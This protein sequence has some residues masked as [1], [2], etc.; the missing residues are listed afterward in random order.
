MK[1]ILSLGSLLLA[2]GSCQSDNAPTQTEASTDQTNVSARLVA[3]KALPLAQSFRARM[4]VGDSVGEWSDAP[5]DKGAQLTLGKVKRGTLVVL[6]VRGYSVVGNDTLWKWFAH[7]SDSAKGAVLSIETAVEAIEPPVI[8]KGQILKLP[9]GSWYTTSATSW[10]NPGVVDSTGTIPALSTSAVVRVRVRVAVP[11]TKDTLFGDTLRLNA[12]RKPTIQP[13]NRTLSKTDSVRISGAS[14]DSLVYCE[15]TNCSDWKPYAK[16][17]PAK[18][19]VLRARAWRDGL[20]SPIDT[21][22]FALEGDPVV[23]EDTVV[24]KPS[25]SP[26]AGTVASTD[27]ITLTPANSGDSIRY[28]TDGSEWKGYT[29]PFPVGDFTV[30]AVALRGKYVSAIAEAKYTVSTTKPSSPSIASSCK[31]LD[32]CD[33][34]TTFEVTSKDSGVTLLYALS[35][36]SSKWERYTSKVP[37]TQS[38]TVFARAVRKEDSSAVQ[39]LAFVIIPPDTVKFTQ[40]RRN[41]DTV[42][43][44]LSTTSGTIW[45]ARGASGA[46]VQYSDSIAVRVRDS[47]R[48][49]SRRGTDSSAPKVFRAVGEKPNPPKFIRLDTLISAKDSIELEAYAPGDVVQYK[50]AEGK[51]VAYTGK[52]APPADGRIEITARSLRNG[53]HSDSVSKAFRV[54]ATLPASPKIDRDT[55]IPGDKFKISVVE[56]NATLEV[57]PDT[58]G[59]SWQSKGTSLEFAASK[60]TM[61]LARSRRGDKVSG[62][63][64]FTIGIRQPDTVRFEASPYDIDTVLVVLR[65]KAGTIW[66]S[67]GATNDSTTYDDSVPVRVN[68]SLWAWTILGTGRSAVKAFFA[69]PT[70]PQSPKITQPT[71]S[72]I[73]PTD[74]IVLVPSARGDAVQYNLGAKWESYTGKIKPGS[75]GPFQ[76]SIRSLRNGLYSDSISKSFYVDTA[77]LA[78]PTISPSIAGVKLNPGTRFTI[79][80]ETG[81][82]LQ[83]STDLKSWRDTTASLEFAAQSDVTIHARAKTAK[84]TSSERTFDIKIQ[85]PDTVKFSAVAHGP[86]S[87]QLTITPVAGDTVVYKRAKNANPA[88]ETKASEAV[89]QIILVPVNDSVTAWTKRGTAYGDKRGY[90][91]APTAPNVPKVSPKG[92][93]VRDTSGIRLSAATPG[94]SVYYRIGSGGEWTPYVNA[95]MLPQGDV[96]LDVR[97]SRNG[98]ST[99]T[100]IGFSVHARPS[101]PLVEGCRSACDPGTTLTFKA[102]VGHD[103][104]AR[105]DAGTPSKRTNPYSAT[106]TTTNTKV[107]AYAD[108]LGYS[109]PDTCVTVTIK[110]PVAPTIAGVRVVHGEM[111]D[112]AYV[113]VKAT[114]VDDQLMATFGGTNRNPVKVATTTFTTIYGIERTSTDSAF[115]VWTKRGTA[116]STQAKYTLSRLPAP[117]ADFEAGDYVAGKTFTFAR[118]LAAGGLGTDTIYLST[119]NGA[120]WTKSASVKLAAN[121]D[122]WAK[123]KRKGYGSAID[124]SAIS[125]VSYTL[126]SSI[127]KTITLVVGDGSTPDQK[128]SFDM[129][130][131]NAD[132]RMTVADSITYLG[133]EFGLRGSSS[134]VSKYE[135]RCVNCANSNYTVLSGA[136]MSFALQKIGINDLMFRV[137]TSWGL[138]RFYRISVHRTAPLNENVEYGTVT[139]GHDGFIYRTVTINGRSWMVE[140]LRYAG[141][142]GTLGVCYQNDTANCREYGRLYTWAEAM[143]ANLDCDA[144]DCSSIPSPH[145]LNCPAEYR[146]PVFEDWQSL[147]E[148]AGGVLSTTT[149]ASYQAANILRSTSPS[150]HEGTWLFTATDGLGFRALPTGFHDKVSGN[151]NGFGK[152]AAWWSG[153]QSYASS[154]TVYGFYADKDMPQNSYAGLSSLKKT[155]RASVRCVKTLP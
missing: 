128:T 154:A 64:T 20:V 40:V 122:I 149:L 143:G 120:S 153:D 124:S 116:S 151:F 136:A 32:A 152:E 92:G 103:I 121:T 140:N 94:D 58:T 145:T 8:P 127:A 130:F 67:R 102:P 111:F 29:G 13:S 68:D 101:Q 70:K 2:L 100:T 132:H 108:S 117:K 80:V 133:V 18:A 71:D 14:G 25:F 15:G 123:T 137:T 150:W 23:P 85:Q 26:G 44:R 47:V 5:Y 62:P 90:R 112:S 125:V 89:P 86:D 93:H 118:D 147:A 148:A 76:I 146:L 115:V 45:Y 41:A 12:P 87:V 144:T 39:R 46:P 114:Q 60:D 28:T 55:G 65:A 50:D 7:A 131:A 97:A 43:V 88:L 95:I 22:T 84:K 36:D 21:A 3:T 104:Y 27:K 61:I 96:A 24:G 54:D 79:S 74:S 81:S 30:K 4:T 141:S 9:A 75:G 19:V 37:L 35:P 129:K 138:V 10:S 126:D 119:D 110:P 78:S 69:K 113:T 66:Y 57:S 49:W 48:A 105:I 53:L 16:A 31:E 106:I 142:D 6:D 91:I 38:A 77:R 98:V 134:D 34:G 56:E 59:K 17:L 63:I 82:T 109:S 107:C 155:T 139:D 83:V 99:D 1:R 72:L 33:P 51:W 42:W 135:V 73:A 52:I 11:G